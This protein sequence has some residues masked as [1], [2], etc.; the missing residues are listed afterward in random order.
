MTRTGSLTA[1]AFAGLAVI[2]PFAYAGTEGVNVDDGTLISQYDAVVRVQGDGSLHVSETVTYDLK[3]APTSTLSRE[4]VTQEQYDAENDRLY[5]VANIAVD[6]GEGFDGEVEASVSEDDGVAD[7]AID[8]GDTVDADERTVTLT[9]DYD[10]SGAVAETA[11]GLEVRWPVVQG[12]DRPIADA[13]VEWNAPDVVW[14]QCLTGPQGSSRP[15]TVSQLVDVSVPT[16][17]QRDVAVG[18]QVVGILGLDSDSGVTPTATA[19]PRASLERSFTASGGPLSIALVVL[20]LGLAFPA[21]LW[22]TRG[23][24][25]VGRR[26]GPVQPISTVDGEL[27]FCPPSAVRP[28][29]MG[30]LVDERADVVDVSST[31]VDLAVRNYLF[32]EE[33]P[34]TLHGRHDWVLRRRNAPGEELLPYERAVFDA[35]FSRGDDVPVSRLEEVL[36]NELG[37]VQALMYADMVGQG[38]FKERPDAVRSRWTTAGWV[39]FGAGAVLTVVLALASRFGLVGLAVVIAG[40]TLAVAGQSTPARTSRGSQVLGELREFRAYLETPHTD[41]IPEQ[42]REELVSRFWPYAL[43]FGLGDR[44]AQALAA[45]DT[46]ATADDPIYWYGAPQDWHLSDAAPSMMRLAAALEAAIAP[47]RLLG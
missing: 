38:W 28:G 43:V 41:D 5:D 32:V 25:A 35:M 7:I 1:W 17:Q 16:M 3:A 47:R 27:M 2:A 31:I 46:D 12:F 24:D 21:W 8:L 6:V 37:D 15:C 39:L 4:I 9:F 10:V 14:L 22:L 11:D 40:A 13:T 42:H 44:W 20:V 19:Q 36:R 23:R 34:R 33:L 30:T 29:Q 18:E 45:T 26:P